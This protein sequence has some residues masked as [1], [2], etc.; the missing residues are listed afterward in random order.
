MV[1]RHTHRRPVPLDRTDPVIVVTVRDRSD[2]PC[3]KVRTPAPSGKQDVW[4]K[5]GDW[6]GETT[7]ETNVDHRRVGS[8]QGRDVTGLYKQKE[9][10]LK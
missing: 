4:G 3:V 8:S 5:G 1:V 6:V 2:F 9:S 10:R 7:S